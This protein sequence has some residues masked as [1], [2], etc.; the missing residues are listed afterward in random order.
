MDFYHNR[1]K[2]LEFEYRHVEIVVVEATKGASCCDQDHRPTL[3][4]CPKCGKALK[5]EE[6]T[7]I[8]TKGKIILSLPRVSKLRARRE[9]EELID[10]V[11]SDLDKKGSDPVGKNGAG[12]KAGSGKRHRPPPKR[13]P[14]RPPASDDD[15][16]AEFPAP[17]PGFSLGEGKDDI[18]VDNEAALTELTEL[19]KELGWGER[20]A[21]MLDELKNKKDGS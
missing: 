12:K 2:V 19:M 3:K 11:F 20:V 5:H 8:I 6:V 13:R 9:A 16:D 18:P 4:F 21:Q 17:P 1:K 15:G 10:R 7:L 14:P